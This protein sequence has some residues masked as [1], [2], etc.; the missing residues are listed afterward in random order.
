MMIIFI[1]WLETCKSEVFLDVFKKLLY[2][3]FDKIVTLLELVLITYS[4]P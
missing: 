2:F 1:N 4:I 3:S